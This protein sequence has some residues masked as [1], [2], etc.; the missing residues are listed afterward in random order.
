MEE[1]GIKPVEG[2]PELTLLEFL[3]EIVNNFEWNK[4]SELWDKYAELAKVPD[5]VDFS[6]WIEVQPA[7][8]ALATMIR[9]GVFKQPAG[10]ECTHPADYLEV[11]HVEM[12]RDVKPK[13]MAEQTD[14]FTSIKQDD[15]VIQQ[16]NVGAT[17][18]KVSC[19]C[20]KCYTNLSL[21]ADIK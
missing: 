21:R 15:Y 17:H 14:G 6:D 3:D 5:N 20:S 2:V 8:D 12:S 9:A 13:T 18:V 7:L 11:Q 16:Y 4:S 10:S 19:R 1:A